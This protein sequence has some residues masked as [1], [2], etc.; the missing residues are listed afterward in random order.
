MSLR[1]R[2]GGVKHRKNSPQATVF[3]QCGEVAMLRAGKWQRRG[4]L[5]EGKCRKRTR[6]SQLARVGSPPSVSEPGG[7]MRG[8]KPNNKIIVVFPSSVLPSRCFGNPPS[9][10][11]E[12]LT[13]CGHNCPKHLPAVAHRPWGI[14]PLRSGKNPHFGRNDI[15]IRAGGRGK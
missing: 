9:P 4:N 12:G 15:V 3:S 11:G 10:E 2:R 7:R 14:S 6:A 13:G 5:P 8:I 1:A